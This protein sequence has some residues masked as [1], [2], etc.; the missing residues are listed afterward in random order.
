MA[1]GKR[2]RSGRIFIVVALILILLVVLGFV[3]SQ[4]ASGIIGALPIPGGQQ[5]EAVT[6]PTPTAPP[7][8]IAILTQNVERGK[9]ITEEMIVMVP[10][11]SNQPSQGLFI[12]DKKEAIGKKPLVSLR[13]HMPLTKDLLTEGDV[14][15]DASFLIPK[16]K[17]AIAIP[18]T[19][20]TSVA[21]APQNGDHISI[22]AS[23]YLVDLDPSFQSKLPNYTAKVTIP[24]PTG[25]D[26]AVTS[27]AS[28]VISGGAT[29]TQ[30]RGE[31]D[32]VL[33][34]PI[35][36]LPS[37]AQRP[38]LVSQTLIYDA[39]VLRVG[40]F[41]TEPVPAASTDLAQPAPPPAQGEATPTPAPDKTKPDVITLIVDP[42][43]AVT[44][45][46]LMLAKAQLNMVL[47]SA[48]DTPENAKVTEAVTLQF[49]MDRYKI[50]LP[51]KQPYG[52]EPRIDTLNYP[53]LTNDPPAPASGAPAQ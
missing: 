45:N 20:L 50:P 30:G 51:A 24:G 27:A 14:G 53:Q 7:I 29:S 28:E 6:L 33:N 52:W 2:R 35:Y 25:E 19:R 22:L 5:Q 40:D 38:R 42:Q 17:V 49:L 12:L 4:L 1:D 15:S 36:A 16:G 43:D 44:L 9:T 48:G 31:V 11:P 21:Y 46:F 26:G 10:Y 3:L 41:N 13:A 34:Q 37:E 39:T 32:S 18:I 47:R 23:L 8:E